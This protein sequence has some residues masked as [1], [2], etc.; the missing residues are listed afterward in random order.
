LFAPRSPEVKA[1]SDLKHGRQQSAS[2][3]AGALVMILSV[4]EAR[5]HRNGRLRR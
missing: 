3:F 4:I 1:A 2:A 5:C